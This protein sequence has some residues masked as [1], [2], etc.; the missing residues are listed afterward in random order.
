[1]WHLHHGQRA[2]QLKH[3]Q[4]SAVC[5]AALKTSVIALRYRCIT[6]R[7]HGW[8]WVRQGLPWSCQASH[9]ISGTH[10]ASSVPWAE[11]RPPLTV[12]M[13]RHRMAGTELRVR[14]GWTG[15][16]QAKLQYNTVLVWI[17]G[18]GPLPGPARAQP[19]PAR[20]TELVPRGNQGH[21]VS[22][23]SR[24]TDTVGATS[25][26]N[27][28]ATT[29]GPFSCYARPGIDPQSCRTR[30]PSRQSAPCL[31]P[32]RYTPEH[33]QLSMCGAVA[34]L[35]FAGGWTSSPLHTLE[36]LLPSFPLPCCLKPCG[37]HRDMLWLF[38]FE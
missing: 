23:P 31:H 27:G 33:E 22:D 18:L 28:Y 25:S 20:E 37:R 9:G 1:M 3:C 4:L 32:V 10:G 6:C 26:V 13:V 7:G 29:S 17:Y 11:E 15:A 8:S 12:A 24:C 35:L 19:R 21:G 2:R 36:L 16:V 14:A 30:N 5:T 34:V 38:V